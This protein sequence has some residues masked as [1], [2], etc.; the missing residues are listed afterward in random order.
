VELSETCRVLYQINLRNNASRWLLLQEYVTMQGPLNVKF[1]F[2]LSEVSL[3]AIRMK[4]LSLTT[5]HCN[6]TLH[7]S[8][9][10]CLFIC[11][12]LS[13]CCALNGR[14]NTEK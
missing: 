6:R 3:S 2:C 13:N 12:Y 11:P 7:S 5:N 8:V 9:P 4:Q 14:V 1:S 10:Y